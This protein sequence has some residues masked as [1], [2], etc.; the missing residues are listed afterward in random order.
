[1]TSQADLPPLD[2]QVE[3]TLWAFVA[4]VQAGTAESGPDDFLVATWL[5]G[6]WEA[7][8]IRLH[9]ISADISREEAERAVHDFI[10]SQRLLYAS[11]PATPG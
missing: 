10:E 9:M 11:L 4:D 7:T 8:L 6:A 1:M 3:A 5:F 2:P